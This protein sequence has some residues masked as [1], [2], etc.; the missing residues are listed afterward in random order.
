VVERALDR[1]KSVPMAEASLYDL[2]TLYDL[3]VG[4]GPCEAFYRELA[5]HT[6]G[7]ILELACGTGRITIPLARDGHEVTGLDVSSAMLRQAQAKAGS[8]NV[9]FVQANMR[10]FDLGQR[11][12]LIIVSCNSL[13][14]LTTN[15]DL[16]A[17]LTRVRKHLTS[18]GLFAFDIVNPDVGVLARSHSECVR[19]DIRPNP[20]SVIA[21]EEFA[22]YDPVRQI[23]AARLRV[24]CPDGPTSE[25]APLQLRLLFPQELPLLLERVGLQLITRYGDFSR[26]PLASDSLNQVCIVR[27]S[28]PD[29]Q[30]AF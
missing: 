25:I 4:I 3:I 16:Q 13:A 17:A 14:H 30:G 26:N 29:Q 19:L 12:P 10:N 1:G 22:T 20:S 9:R 27:S 8:L 11:F 18:T 23:R 24:V 28:L 6:G 7:P 2:P 5:Q 21:I 15:A